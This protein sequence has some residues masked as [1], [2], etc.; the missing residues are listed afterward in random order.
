MTILLRVLRRRHGND[1]FWR[2]ALLSPSPIR[3]C[4]KAVTGDKTAIPADRLPNLDCPSSGRG[5]I[6]PTDLY[7]IVSPNGLD[8][9]IARLALDTTSWLIWLTEPVA[10]PVRLTSPCF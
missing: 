1:V 9:N 6:A 8:A 3:N 5:G 2:A 7:Q 4:A 10:C